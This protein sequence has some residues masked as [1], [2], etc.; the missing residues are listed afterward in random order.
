MENTI[1]V[2][3]PLPGDGEGVA[4]AWVDCGR[5]YSQLDP[6]LYQV[7]AGEDIGSRFEQLLADDPGPGTCRLIADLSGEAVG[8]LVALLRPA[9][10]RPEAQ[11][12]RAKTRA[13]VWVDLLIVQEHARGVGV[14]SA[15]LTGAENWALEQGAALV[16]LDTW[17]RSPLS[18]PFYEHRG[19]G[20]H[21]VQFR[22]ML[23]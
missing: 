12:S 19:Y 1:T 23:H 22:K 18:V 21:G 9:A 13:R 3:A 8:Y 6:E 20:R 17:E 7:P 5:Y 14:G 16:E 10:T 2:R 15:L 11:F 4:A